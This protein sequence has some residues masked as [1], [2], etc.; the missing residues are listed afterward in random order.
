MVMMKRYTVQGRR[1]R[2]EAREQRYNALG[3]LALVAMAGMAGWHAMHGPENAYQ[4]VAEATGVAR[5]NLASGEIFKTQPEQCA[6]TDSSLALPF[7]GIVLYVFVG[8]AV[9]TDEY[10]EPT[11]ALISADLNLSPDVAGATFM[12]AGSSAPEL[13][14][15]VVDAF[16]SKASV[17]VGTILGSAMFNLLII[18]AGTALIGR[19]EDGG[20]LL[21]QGYPIGR[22]SVFY[23]AA[24]GL[25]ALLMFND[26]NLCVMRDDR[27]DIFNNRTDQDPED[28]LC[29]VGLVTGM[30]GLLLMLVYVLYIIFMAHNRQIHAWLHEHASCIMGTPSF[31]GPDVKSLPAKPE[32]DDATDQ[33]IEDI[34][35]KDTPKPTRTLS[36]TGSVISLAESVVME[37]EGKFDDDEDDFP[38]FP[39]KTRPSSVLG[40]VYWLLALPFRLIFWIT[41]PTWLPEG[42][43]RDLALFI[44]NV[45][46]ITGLTFAMVFYATFGGCLLEIDPFIIGIV[47]LAIGTSVPDALASFIVARNG[48]GDMAISNALG[49]NVFDILLG[50]GLPWF[51][52]SLA[53]PEQVNAPEGRRDGQF[54]VT[55]GVVAGLI[56]LVLGLALFVGSL[57]VFKW[58]MHRPIAILLVLYYVAFLVL[59]IM[60]NRCEIP[61][62]IELDCS[63]CGFDPGL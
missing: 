5:R 58:K 20:P 37:E 49:S 57:V 18:A 46:W 43:V 51:L 9:I 14:T 25:L 16:F 15:S 17:G 63:R 38:E 30:E 8:L 12:A 35:D 53:F 61:V 34:D 27:F 3:A 6:G 4:G 54:V 24:I 10:F 41:M 42:V 36:R 45:T 40:A 60:A 52:S 47:V 23:L 31:Q 7:F 39:L 29:F 33:T 2:R 28:A 44:I 62:C 19:S 50:L 1:R 56:T 22:D 59:I 11:L 26:G 21:I 55:N 48:H 13:L 32:E